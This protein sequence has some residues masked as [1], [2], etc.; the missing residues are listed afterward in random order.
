MSEKQAKT[1]PAN[2]QLAA[3]DNV[4]GNGIASRPLKQRRGFFSL[5]EDQRHLMDQSRL[6]VRPVF[7]YLLRDF[8][9]VQQ[10]ELGQVV[11]EKVSVVFAGR[12]GVLHEAAKER[13]ED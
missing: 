6:S 9:I 5:L 7:S 11:D 1:A 13:E 4:A 3:L 8:L 2:V 10:P 12:H